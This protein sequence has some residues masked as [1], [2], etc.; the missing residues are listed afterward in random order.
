VWGFN[1]RRHVKKIVMFWYR[2]GFGAGGKG[3]TRQIRDVWAP[4]SMGVHCIAHR[5]NLA[6]QPLSNLTFFFGL[7]VFMTNLHSYFSHSP[8]CHLKFQKLVVII[9]TNGNKI[10][11]N[12]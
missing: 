3:V 5:I 2:W 7:D 12:V 10:L 6:M 8:K 4:F 11:K 1:T 9:E